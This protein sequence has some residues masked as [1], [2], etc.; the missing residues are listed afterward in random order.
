MWL[1]RTII[2]AVRDS[3]KPTETLSWASL[4]YT[5]W[6]WNGISCLKYLNTTNGA[7][8]LWGSSKFANY[9]LPKYTSINSKHL[10][11][12]PSVSLG[13]DGFNSN[14]RGQCRDTRLFWPE[15]IFYRGLWLWCS[16]SSQPVGWL[17]F[18]PYKGAGWRRW[19]G[20]CV[21]SWLLR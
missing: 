12:S 19:R 11:D 18:L 17:N 21:P 3:R 16:W 15:G 13:C 4:S 9:H 14:D 10:L 1:K 7:K 2:L 6:R 20:R 8:G 5:P